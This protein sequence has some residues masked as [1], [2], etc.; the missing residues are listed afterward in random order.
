MGALTVLLAVP[1]FPDVLPP[2]GQRESALTVWLAVLP[3]TG[4]VRTIAPR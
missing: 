1:V 4:V 3:P 2:A